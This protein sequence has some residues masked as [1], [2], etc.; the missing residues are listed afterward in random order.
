MPWRNRWQSLNALRTAVRRRPTLAASPQ[1]SEPERTAPGSLVPPAR[2]LPGP[3]AAAVTQGRFTLA[4]HT[5]PVMSMAFSPNGRFL[6][7][8]GDDRTVR[9]W[10]P[11]T[12]TPVG[13]RLTG[14]AGSV[15]SVAFSPDGRLLA[16]SGKDGTVQLWDPVTRLAGQHRPLRR[17][18]RVRHHPPRPRR[19]DHPR[20]LGRTH[21]LR[22]RRPRTPRR[23]RR[24]LQEG[25]HRALPHL[26]G[27][28]PHRRRQRLH[29]RPQELTRL[30]G[31]RRPRP[32]ISPSKRHLARHA[33]LAV[34]SCDHARTAGEVVEAGSEDLVDHED[35]EQVDSPHVLVTGERFCWAKARS[36]ARSVARVHSPTPR[37]TRDVA[38]AGRA[39]LRKSTRPADHRERVLHRRDRHRNHQSVRR[40]RAWI[41][42]RAQRPRHQTP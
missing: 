2:P 27:R 21:R 17:R 40:D 38:A 30:L 10:D 25:H 16:T 42:V 41:G 35:V 37:W 31:R 4:G 29:V 1:T 19:T 28:R 23:R 20:H 18:D 36:H 33:R 32:R 9:L 13:D 15:Y 8:A 39:L 34:S 14:H 12:R 5:G 11:V 6:A 26:P 7:T 24:R 3:H 22:Q